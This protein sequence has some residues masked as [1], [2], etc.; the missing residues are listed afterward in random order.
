M[1]KKK[2]SSLQIGARL[3]FLSLALTP[4]SFLQIKFFSVHLLKCYTCILSFTSLHHLI[5]I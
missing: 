1:D 2:I 4:H 5:N 3:V